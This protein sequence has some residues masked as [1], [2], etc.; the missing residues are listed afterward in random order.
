MGYTNRIVLNT[1]IGILLAVSLVVG[2]ATLKE[3]N[4]PY[5]NTGKL[6]QENASAVGESVIMSSADRKSLEPNLPQSNQVSASTYGVKTLMFNEVDPIN[7]VIQF[8]LALG[9]G[10]AVFLIAKRRLC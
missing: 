6:S 1:A 3:I 9:V 8:S 2:L 10:F 7:L 4:Q 5:V